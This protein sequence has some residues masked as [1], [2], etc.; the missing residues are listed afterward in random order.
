MAKMG[1]KFLGLSIFYWVLIVL[2]VLFFFFGMGRVSEG[3]SFSMN[4]QTNSLKSLKKMNIPTKTE[5]SYKECFDKRTSGCKWS[6]TNNACYCPP[7]PQKKT[8]SSQ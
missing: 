6:E 1:K 4:K 2:V 8:K 3:F 7:N 5:D